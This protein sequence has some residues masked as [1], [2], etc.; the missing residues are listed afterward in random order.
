APWV[1]CGDP[2]TDFNGGPIAVDPFG[3]GSDFGF[4]AAY[5]NKVYIGP[6]RN[7]NMA[8]RMEPDGSLPTNCY[9]TFTKDTETANSTETHENGA[10]GIPPARFRTIGHTGCTTNSADINLGCGP[11][12]ENGRGLFVNG[13]V[14]GTEYLFITGGKSTG[15]N[16][17][18]YQTTDTDTT[19]DFSFVDLS[20][21]FNSDSI[22]GNK[23]TESIVVF[24]NKVYW[25]E[26]GNLD[27]RPYFVKLNNLN[28]QSASGSD[29]GWMYIRYMS[30]MGN[31]NSKPNRADRIGGTLYAFNDRLYLANNGSVRN[32]SD[33]NYDDIRPGCN[34]TTEDSYGSG[35]GF[36]GLFACH[37]TCINDGGIIRSTNNDPAP[38]SGQNNCT[39]WTDIT[40]SGNAKYTNYFSKVI[41]KLADV[42]P[43][44]RPVPAFTEFNGNLYMI[45]NACTT[46]VINT[47]CT[48]NGFNS[49]TDDISCP[50]GSEVP[51][52]WKCVPGVD[53]ECDSGDWSL[54]AENGTTGRSNMGDTENK[55][56]TL[57]IANG[58]HLYMGF[59]NANGV[60]IWMTKD[61]VTNPASAS[62]FEQTGSNGLGDPSSYKSLWSAISVQGSDGYYIYVSVGNGVVPVAIF[63]QRND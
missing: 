48:P 58:N 56:A 39:G 62:D 10:A 31:W 6:N 36:L 4:L 61:G 47:E 1:G 50:S 25:M 16:D 14:G 42:I 55:F 51:Q 7:G 32:T 20:A 40:P 19:L 23:G 11:D 8:N 17:Y 22:E 34:A 26:P 63:R 44:N 30:G 5:H 18:L 33:G 57:L 41:T 35:C 54:V 38:C 60:E 28:A 9:F 45:R 53:G 29:S 15:N 27:Y 37:N 49:C 46:N 12:N 2:I 13:T 3:D 59:D 24:N 43:A 52:L 21:T